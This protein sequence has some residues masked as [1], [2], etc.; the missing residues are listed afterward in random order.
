[1]NARRMVLGPDRAA[2][3][4]P[5][6]A[7]EVRRLGLVFLAAAAVLGLLCAWKMHRAHPA[8]AP[9]QAWPAVAFALL[10]LACLGLGAR[11]GGIHRAWTG[12]GDLLGRIISPLVLA[13]LYFVVVTPF[14]LAA[15]VFRGDRLGL[16]PDRNAATYW[17]EPVSRRTD[18][19]RLLRQY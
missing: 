1:M 11:A 6:T 15:R 10:G 4:K 8:H 9:W 14:A 2:M 7:A 19:A 13:V 17:N 12:F 5:A 3:G 18:R 16:R